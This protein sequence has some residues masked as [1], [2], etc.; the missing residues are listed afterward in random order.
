M[1]D[2]IPVAAFDFD[3]TLCPGDSIVPFLRFCIQEGLA[4]KAQFFRA[5]RG[6]L[7]QKQGKSPLRMRNP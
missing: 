5:A 3:G 6:F 7:L 4:G 1:S 2:L